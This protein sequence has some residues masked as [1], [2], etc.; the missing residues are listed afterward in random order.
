[1]NI[2]FTHRNSFILSVAGSAFHRFF[3]FRAGLSVDYVHGMSLGSP[4]YCSKWHLGC[5]DD[6]SFHAAG[7]Y[8]K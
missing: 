4:Q 3:L 2:L 5:I 7:D 6:E 1:M 8:T